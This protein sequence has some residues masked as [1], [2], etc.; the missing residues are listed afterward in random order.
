MKNDN[1]KNLQLCSRLQKYRKKKRV[2]QSEMAEY[3]GLSKNYISALER[4]VNRCNAQTMIDYAQ[5]LEVSL[6]VLAGIKST[7]KDSPIL[8]EIQEELSL[9]S[10]EDQRKLLEILHILKR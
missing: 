4:G 2:T 3:C 8:P 7:K 9:M 1:E 10:I 6:D 5:K